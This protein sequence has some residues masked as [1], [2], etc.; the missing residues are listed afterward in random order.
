MAD[1]EWRD[2]PGETRYEVSNDGLIRTKP[3]ILKPWALP[4]GHLHVTLSNRKRMLVHRAVALAFLPNPEE[5]RCVNHKNGRPADNR[6]DN[7]EWS[8]HGEN[9]AHGYRENGR[10][11]YSTYPVVSVDADGVVTKYDNVK[12]AASAHRVTRGAIHAALRSGGRCRG[13]FWK[14]A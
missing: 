3:R 13:L 6:L 8:T 11:H 4:E 12:T 1:R 2:I 9:I 5:K 14:R 10:V 7:L